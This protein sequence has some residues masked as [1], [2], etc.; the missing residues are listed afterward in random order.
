LPFAEMIRASPLPPVGVTVI[1]ASL[2]DAVH[3]S[4]ARASFVTMTLAELAALSAKASS[5]TPVRLTF[6]RLA[7]TS[8]DTGTVRVIFEFASVTARLAVCTPA[9]NMAAFAVTSIGPGAEPEAGDTVNQG[10]DPAADQRRLLPL[11]ETVRAIDW[12]A[13]ASNCRAVAFSLM[14]SV[15]T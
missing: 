15:S 13:V 1:Q 7:E 9:L 14:G 10:C 4:A 8:N 2:A 5:E 12:P 11:I 3:V 6:Q